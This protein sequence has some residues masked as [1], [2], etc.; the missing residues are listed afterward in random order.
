MI[1]K[2]IYVS[3]YD[4]YA[5]TMA[6]ET[7]VESFMRRSYGPEGIITSLSLRLLEI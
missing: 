6:F 7:E 5:K 4:T 1:C 3:L 2:C